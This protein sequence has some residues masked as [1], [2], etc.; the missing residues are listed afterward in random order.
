MT[1]KHGYFLTR[2]IISFRLMVSLVNGFATVPAATWLFAS[3]VVFGAQRE[4][5]TRY[6]L[7]VPYTTR[8]DYEGLESHEQEFVDIDTTRTPKIGS[9]FKN[10]SKAITCRNCFPRRMIFAR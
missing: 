2:K 6:F 7:R 5:Q 8:R 3:N 1:M 4:Q 10:K 9:T